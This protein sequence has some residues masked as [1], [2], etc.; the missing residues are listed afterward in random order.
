MSGSGEKRWQ[1]LEGDGG[2]WHPSRRGLVMG[3]GGIA[4]AGALAACGNTASAP[5][6]GT[7]TGA[8]GSPKRGGNFRLGVTGGGSKMSF[9]IG[10]AS[11]RERV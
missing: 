11:C 4:A 10:R 5:G 9:E 7:S 6:T 8:T 3:A 2:L 1:V